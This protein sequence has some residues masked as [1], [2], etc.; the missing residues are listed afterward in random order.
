MKKAKNPNAPTYSVVV[1]TECSKKAN[2]LICERLRLEGRYHAAERYAPQ[3]QIKQ[4]FNC[5]GYGHRANACTKNLK[6]GKC[7]QEHETRTCSESKTRCANCEGEHTAWHH[8]CSHRQTEYKRLE[9]ARAL[10]PSTFG[11]NL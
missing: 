5:Q 7:G 6:C 2:K 4:C 3:C 1:F 9:Q 8:E 11:T 10:T